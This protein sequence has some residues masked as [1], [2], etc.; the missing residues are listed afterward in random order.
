[1]DKACFLNDDEIKE[2]ILAKELTKSLYFQKYKDRLFCE[3]RDC[4]AEMIFREVTKG[5]RTNYFC[6]RDN[7]KHISGCKNEV[8]HDGTKASRLTLSGDGVTAEDTHVQ[9]SLDELFKNYYKKL[10]P[11]EKT[12]GGV[13][14]KPRKKKPIQLVDG[15]VKGFD[16]SVVGHLVMGGGEQ[17]A[18]VEVKE[19]NIYT[20]EL[21]DIG[22]TLKTSINKVPSIVDDIRIFEQE[23]FIDIHDID[24][25]K[26]IIYFGEP[27]RTR[28]EQEFKLLHI[29]QKY[30]QDCQKE[31]KL[32]IC[33]C[34]AEVSTKEDRAFIQIYDYKDIRFNN[35]P[36]MQII[37][38]QVEE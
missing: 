28:H 9:K 31:N 8:T 15:D 29:I 26:G 18:T 13:K 24:G 11:P 5:N 16:E 4:N 14:R 30:I 3:N 33:T 12:S 35:T 25:S 20:K 38:K 7:S 36:F 10:Y 6:T 21:A 34:Y 17:A 32:I 22:S 23:V 27:F 19:P 2:D 1:M 37:R